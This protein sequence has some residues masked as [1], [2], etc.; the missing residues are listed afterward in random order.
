MNEDRLHPAIFASAHNAPV[1][2]NLRLHIDWLAG[3]VG[4]LTVTVFEWAG[5]YAR[6]DAPF[7]V[8]L[9]SRPRWVAVGA[10]C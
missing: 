2:A 4:F 9:F 3:L 7:R 10:H 8:T 6:R 5:A 1:E